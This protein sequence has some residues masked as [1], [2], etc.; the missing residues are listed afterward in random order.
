MPGKKGVRHIH[1]GDVPSR[2]RCSIDEY[3]N[4]YRMKQ[5]D[6]AVRRGDIREARWWEAR[7]EANRRINHGQQAR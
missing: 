6:L 3:L 4:V 7:I 1:E 2:A 5:M